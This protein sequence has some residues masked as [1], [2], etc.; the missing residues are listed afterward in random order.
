MKAGMPQGTVSN[1]P[2]GMNDTK[3]CNSM[4]GPLH[5]TF[6]H[7]SNKPHH[8]HTQLSTCHQQQQQQ[9][10]PDRSQILEGRL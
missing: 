1:L 2:H 7:Q 4:N 10:P 3:M 9:K 6:L 8:Y 5:V